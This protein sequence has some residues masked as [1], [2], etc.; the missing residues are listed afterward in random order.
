M[1]DLESFCENLFE[2]EKKILDD[3]MSHLDNG[4][5]TYYHKFA[6]FCIKDSNRFLKDKLGVD[7]DGKI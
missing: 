6:L 2:A 1:N 4:Y 5:I 3:I 7:L